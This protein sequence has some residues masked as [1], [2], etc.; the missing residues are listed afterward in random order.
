MP[1]FSI[2]TPVYNPPAAALKACIASM[3]SQTFR[4]WEWCLVDDMSTKPH[5]RKILDKALSGDMRIRVTY[6]EKNG[7]IVAASQAALDM[8]TGEF[9][10]LLDHDDALHA[11]ALQKVAARL[12]ID[13]TIDYLYTDEDKIDENGLHYDFFRKPDWDKERLRGQNYCCHFSVF[14]STLLDRVGGFREGFDGSQDYDI[15]LRATEQARTV[16]HI[17]EVLY[18][19]RCVPGSAA[20]EVMAKP[21]AYQ[22]G[23]RA[24]SEHFQRCDIDAKPTL[25]DSG[26]YQYRRCSLKSMPLVSIII[27]TRGDRK[28]VWGVTTCLVVNAV[29][30]IIKNSTYS[31]FEI[32]VINDVHPD[33]TSFHQFNLPS[34]TRVRIV[35]Y[36]KPFNFSEKC[37]VGFFAS[38]GEV[39][40]MLNDDTQVITPDWIEQMI[41]HFDDP[42]VAMVGP[43]LLLEDGRIQSAGHT[44]ILSPHHLGAGESPESPGK[45]GSYSVSRNVSGITG[46]CSAI[47]RSMYLELGG[48]SLD[49][50]VNFNDVD[51]CFKVL[52]AG[53]RI[54]WTPMA[55]L[56]HF[57]SMTRV[58]HV[59]AEEVEA[60]EKRWKRYFGVDVYTP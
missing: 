6:R 46:A 32:L 60:L 58:K 5:V 54:V 3:Q 36:D 45:W 23:L 15:I 53:Y 21:Y 18:H 59:S 19:W 20:A 49:F 8:A 48:F 11:T 1:K 40:I 38:N 12:D 39:V 47:R 41:G 51:F 2:V 17:P 16:A 43:M 7:G 29:E 25:L 13:S 22:A 57:E 42:E 37:N 31:N 44:N 24:L 34:D 55:R 28:R 30:S 35:S 27:P 10:G 14:R 9:V 50:P 26:V 52:D 4:D 33:G 56:Y